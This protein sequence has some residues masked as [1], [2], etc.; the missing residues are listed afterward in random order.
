[1]Q[2]FIKKLD[3]REKYRDQ[4]LLN[5][6]PIYKDRL[7]W[8]AQTFRHL[9]HLMP[10]QTILEI[11]S[12]RSLFTSSL[13][14][15]TK[16]KNPITCL[17]FNSATKPS[18]EN[19]VGVDLIKVKN[20]RDELKD[21]KFDYIVGIDLFDKSYCD[22]FLDRV[23]NLLNPG[24]QFV[25]YESNPW[26]LYLN[27][28][29]FVSNI[30]G[31][32]DKRQLLNRTD[33]YQ[34]ISDV[35]FIKV[36]SLYNDFVYSPLT[37]S[38][39]WFLRNLSIILENTPVIRTFSGSILIHAQKP[40]RNKPIPKLSLCEHKEFDN[41][42]SVV[43]PC[44]NEEKNIEILIRNLEILY[45]EYIHEIIPVDDNS[46]DNTKN[47]LVKLAK[48]DSRVKPIY[49]KPPR[50]VGRAL[51]EGYA[52]SEAPYILSLDCDFHQ[53]LPEITDIFDAASKGY[54]IVIGS[55]FSRHSVLLNYPLNKIIAN[56]GF[57][58][59]AQIMFRRG[60]R[61]LTNNLKLIKRKVL[62]N[63]E[64]DQPDFSVNAEIGLRCLLSG[65]PYIEIPIS[66]INRDRE[67]GVTSFRL[68]EVGMNYWKVLFRIWSEHKT[69]KR[70][71]N[72]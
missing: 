46:T 54:D 53:L 38:L 34:L 43:I 14:K 61:D 62:Q 9:V 41:A 28:K 42:V 45:G 44:Y 31:N 63:F 17:Y 4:Y 56:R 64:L 16:G 60:F 33:L 6:D 19:D 67:M 13:L 55:R 5:R 40:P 32:K 58:L 8:R 65:C 23:Y 12:G 50:G 59:L 71:Y 70:G 30:I 66:W 48:K 35:G 72:S 1:M 7:L 37:K 27:F 18:I 15:A 3:Y 47:I 24:G 22:W 49:R 11:G 10:G 52:K 21:K 36:Y 68:M 57:H 2:E 69:T 26:N 39:I 25:F 51:R 29:R 20:L